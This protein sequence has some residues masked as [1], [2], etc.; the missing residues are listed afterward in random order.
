MAWPR[1]PLLD[2]LAA[3]LRFPWL[4]LRDRRAGRQ[5]RPVQDRT[6]AIGPSDILLVTCLRNERSRMPR[7][8][9]H[10][11]RLGVPHIPHR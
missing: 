5:L 1:T 6:A 3:P 2:A 8:V 10:Y 7:F 4:A 9:E 11:R